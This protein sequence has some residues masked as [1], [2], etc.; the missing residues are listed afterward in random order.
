MQGK[1]KMKWMD[2]KEY[3]G[4]FKDGK[5]DGLGKYKWNDGREYVGYWLGNKQHGLGK[6]V[7][8][9]KETYGMWVNGT[10]DKWLNETD[11]QMLNEEYQ[12]QCEQI[13]NFDQIFIS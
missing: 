12:T 1:G 2:G 11:M 6:Y 9:G 10:R 13:Q 8:G 3:I 5:K 4:E 7:K